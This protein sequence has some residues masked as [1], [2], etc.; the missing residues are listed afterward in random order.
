MCVDGK[1]GGLSCGTSDIA[2]GAVNI[3]SGK[4]NSRQLYFTGRD[5]GSAD[6]SIAVRVEGTACERTEW[7]SSS[8]V[9]CRHAT[10]FSSTRTATAVS[11]QY[12]QHLSTVTQA[13]S[14]DVLSLSRTTVVNRHNSG[15]SSVSLHGTGFGLVSLTHRARLG[16]TAC[17]MH[18]L[19]HSE[20]SVSCLMALGNLASR[21]VALSAT[22]HTSSLSSM[23]SFDILQ[24]SEMLRSNV[25]GT[26]AFSI[27]IQG[28][29]LGVL[30]MSA[31][32]R[33]GATQMEASVW[34]SD[35]S[36][37][38]FE[39]SSGVRSTRRVSMTAG[40]ESGSI[41]SAFSYSALPLL[42]A[43]ARVDRGVQTPEPV[44]MEYAPVNNCSDQS[45]GCM[46]QVCKHV[47]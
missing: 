4:I 3:H 20:T 12:S 30:R 21:R 41:T 47:N 29:G 35:T 19:W 42:G 1:H 25:P 40:R 9:L 7:I 2:I 8:W 13:F 37:R 31:S 36:L 23:F 18:S 28:T 44:A 24:M 5:L 14:I 43:A 10:G 45:S 27:T 32:A 26:G 15:S 34:V 39:P 17:R 6:M 38:S 11:V 22:S 46:A 16:D 33:A